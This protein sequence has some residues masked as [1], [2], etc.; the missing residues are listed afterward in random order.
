MKKGKDGDIGTLYGS[1][2][3]NKKHGAGEKPKYYRIQ[4]VILFKGSTKWIVADGLLYASKFR[5][6]DITIYF[7]Y[8]IFSSTL[9]MINTHYH[10]S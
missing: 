10:Y 4:D 2:I 8:Y 3:I 9:K 7:M 6:E 5:V 1:A